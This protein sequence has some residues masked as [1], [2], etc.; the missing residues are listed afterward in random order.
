MFMSS[1]DAIIALWSNLV[2]EPQI[3]AMCY[4]RYTWKCLET[5]LIVISKILLGVEFHL[6]PI[7]RDEG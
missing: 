2:G 5:F 3:G 6:H 7:G 1:E 4:P